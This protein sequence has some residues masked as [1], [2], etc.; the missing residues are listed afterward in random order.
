MDGRFAFLL[1]ALVAQ[2]PPGCPGEQRPVPDSR[3]PE[4]KGKVVKDGLLVHLAFSG[5]TRDSSQNGFHGDGFSGIWVNEIDPEEGSSR[6][7]AM[8][9]GGQVVRLPRMDNVRSHMMSLTAI[10]LVEVGNQVQESTILEVNDEDERPIW[11]LTA[12]K[13]RKDGPVRFAVKLGDRTAE[14]PNLVVSEEIAKSGF[15]EIAVSFA[16]HGLALFVNR[17]KVASHRGFEKWSTHQGVGGRWVNHVSYG[18]NLKPARG[19]YR[20]GRGGVGGFAGKIDDLRIYNYSTDEEGIGALSNLKDCDP[21]DCRELGLGRHVNECD[22]VTECRYCDVFPCDKSQGEQFGRVTVLSETPCSDEFSPKCS[23]DS[24]GHEECRIAETFDCSKVRY[25]PG[26]CIHPEETSRI[27]G[28]CRDRE[29]CSPINCDSTPECGLGID[30]QC[31]GTIDCLCSDACEENGSNAQLSWK[32]L[33]GAKAYEVQV[34]LKDQIVSKIVSASVRKTGLGELGVDESKLGESLRFRVRG[35]DSNHMGGAWSAWREIDDGKSHMVA[36]CEGTSAPSRFTSRFKYHQSGQ[37]AEIEDPTPGRPKTQYRYNSRGDLQGVSFNGERVVS[38]V[39]YGPNSRISGYQ[40]ASSGEF[41][42]FNVGFGFDDQSRVTEKR[43]SSLGSRLRTTKYEYNTLGQ[44]RRKSIRS[45]AL[46]LTQNYSYGA[47]HHELTRVGY[48]TEAGD[49]ALDYSYDLRGNLVERSDLRAGPLSL[50]GLASQQYGTNNRNQAESLD[51]FGNITDSTGKEYVFDASAN[52]IRVKSSLGDEENV[53]LSYDGLGRLVR[54]DYVDRY[55]VHHR[56]PF[57]ALIAE[58]EV[59]AEEGCWKPGKRTSYVHFNGGAIMKSEAE[60]ETGA[61]AY[62]DRSAEGTSEL[63]FD[64]END[65]EAID[66][67]WSEYGNP[68]FPSDVEPKFGIDGYESVE[69]TGLWYAKARYYDSNKGRFLTVD[70]Q[71]DVDT[72]DSFRAN[73][74][75]YARANPAFFGDNDGRVTFVRGVTETGNFA[76]RLI[77]MMGYLDSLDFEYGTPELGNDGTLSYRFGR[78]TVRLG[79]VI[80]CSTATQAAFVQAINSFDGEING[81][82]ITDRAFNLLRRTWHPYQNLA[83]EFRSGA[84]GEIVRFG[85]GEMVGS[86]DEARRGDVVQAWRTNGGSKGHSFIIL[87]VYH[88]EQGRAVG[89]DMVSATD[90]HGAEIAIRYETRSAAAFEEMY[91]A[92]FYDVVE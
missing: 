83:S 43:T 9:T 35:I 58:T 21:K 19:S 60:G 74:F 20:V 5:D 92:R 34:E 59:T 29:G 33:R 11:S 42:G 17:K 50:A 66:M 48:S 71:R 67:V 90:M 77:G 44:V 14:D 69:G 41:P 75:Q 10:A 76:E 32:L 86:I 31:G 16:N 70:P 81:V 57:G 15:L 26:E 52:L 12:I 47:R 7:S 54:T 78:T 62:F 30:D 18:F 88:N 36:S 3:P 23:V 61:R 82:P 24:P 6:Q 56:D 84:A 63:V 22:I 53:G 1:V 79:S 49:D 68:L 64:E 13:R 39:D 91:I 73:L 25:V 38:R 87:N 80:D 45:R 55:V 8:F 65:F 28:E 72:A 40:V 89:Y 4:P 2:V 51:S 37:I 27:G 85:M 46:G